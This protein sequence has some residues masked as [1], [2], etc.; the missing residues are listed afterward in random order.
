MLI[1][2]LISLRCSALVSVS[3]RSITDGGTFV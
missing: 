3:P 2:E 1:A